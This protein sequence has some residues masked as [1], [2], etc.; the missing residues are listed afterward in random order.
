QVV[1]LNIA[2]GLAARDFDVTL[3]HR[4]RRR[5]PLPPAGTKA[6]VLTGYPRFIGRIM[7]WRADPSGFSVLA[8]PVLFSLIAP[9]PLR[10]LLSLVRYLRA[11]RPA[12]LISATTYMNLVAIWARGLAGGPTPIVGRGPRPLAH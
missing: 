4:A 10:L 3:L 1:M 8:R 6:Q 9:E 2:R 7:A 5:E 11:E 12:G